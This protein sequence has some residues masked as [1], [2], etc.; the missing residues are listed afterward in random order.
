M[1][2]KQDRLYGVDT[3]NT[4]DKLQRSVCVCIRNYENMSNRGPGGHF[5]PHNPIHSGGEGGP[6]GN[7]QTGRRLERTRLR[8]RE[9]GHFE[10]NSPHF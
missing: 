4:F 2:S 7:V 8:V 9:L 6:C 10:R 5:R 1:D 3:R